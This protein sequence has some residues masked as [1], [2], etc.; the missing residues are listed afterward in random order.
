M[1]TPEEVAKTKKLAG[2]E[3]TSI[4]PGVVELLCDSHEELREE[5]ERLG[6]LL[7]CLAIHP[8]VEHRVRI[9]ANKALEEKCSHQKK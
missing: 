6:Q 1:L 9:I 4:L 7:A 8:E 2:Q 5:V 3:D